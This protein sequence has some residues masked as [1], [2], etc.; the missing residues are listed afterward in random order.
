MVHEKGSAGYV[1]RNEHGHLPSAAGMKVMEASVPYAE[2]VAAQAGLQ[3]AILK[4]KANQVCI[5]GDSTVLISWINS[6][7]ISR[8]TKHPLIK[9]INHPM[10]KNTAI[11]SSRTVVS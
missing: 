7:S 4:Y 3:T 2:M 5:K 11:F 10:G 8:N 9:D 1:I 6:Y